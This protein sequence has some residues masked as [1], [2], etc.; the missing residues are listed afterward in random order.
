[1]SGALGGMPALLARASKTPVPAVAAGLAFLILF[2]QPMATLGQ[3]WWRDPEAGHGLL[4]GPLA[5]I[6]GWRRGRAQGARPQPVWG[7]VILSGAILLRYLSGLAAELFTMRLSMFGGMAGLIVFTLGFRQVVHWWLPGALLLLS[8]PI[9]AVV[10]NTIAFPLQIKASQIGATLLE[11]RQVPVALGGNVIHLPGRSL[12]VTEACSGLRSLT[13]LISLGV[14]TGGLWLKTPWS[15]LAILALSVPVALALNGL[16]VFVTG[17]LVYYVGPAWGEGF[18]HYT[19]G[20]ALFIV[21][22]GILGAMTWMAGRAEA[23][24]FARK[25]R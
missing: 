25:A 17:F 5:L 3:D 22:F 18:L 16:R 19:E 21:A 1:M 7:I 8:V 10:L 15:R 12:F 24:A 9:P 11:M 13:A 6:L 14:L 20:W 4:L 2:W 23:A